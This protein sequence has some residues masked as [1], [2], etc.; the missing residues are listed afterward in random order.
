VRRWTGV[1]RG[2]VVDFDEHVGLGVVE[3]DGEGA[4]RYPFHCTQIAGGTRSIEVG[5]VVTFGVVA[6]RRGRWEAAEVTPS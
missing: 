1:H 3:E 6:A 2:L 4:W 5:T